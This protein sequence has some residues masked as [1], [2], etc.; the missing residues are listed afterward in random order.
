MMMQRPARMKDQIME[1]Y[2]THQQMTYGVD[3]TM[4]NNIDDDEDN[5]E[6]NDD[7]ED[8]PIPSNED[9][10]D[11]KNKVRLWL[12]YDNTISK[13]KLALRERKKAQE[14]LTDKIGAFMS[15]YNIEDLN[16]KQG[17]L[18]CKIVDVKVPLTQRVIKERL[19]E[20]LHSDEKEKD[21]DEVIN[22]VFKRD[23]S[24]QKIVIKRLK[25]GALS[26]S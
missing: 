25:R 20:N 6:G 11:F 21:P 3:N 26:I 10:E 9:L 5:H 15:R 2:L 1:N 22:E 4:H 16:T 17:K 18:R 14:A 8:V 13:L 19:T 23:G 12:D 7:D 24:I